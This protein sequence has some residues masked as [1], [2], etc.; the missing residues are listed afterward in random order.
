MKACPNCN[1]Q[2]EGIN[3]NCPKC[4]FQL[5]S[6]EEAK[7][8]LDSMK[9]YSN[10]LNSSLDFSPQGI[11]ATYTYMEH[12]AIELKWV[13]S[14]ISG[15]TQKHKELIQNPRLI[16]DNEWKT[17]V[18]TFLMAFFAMMNGMENKEFS[19]HIVTNP[20]PGCHGIEFELTK[21]GIAVEDLGKNYSNF[22]DGKDA[23]GLEKAQKCIS[24]IVARINN[25]ASEMEKVK[26]KITSNG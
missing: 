16:R 6:L 11:K 21:L 15:F 13:M 20:P 26:G 3:I 24:E 17:S 5:M 19:Q 23:D 2:I 4:G 1:Q 14:A 22:L 18:K 25:T 8:L 10:N 12:V 7:S 9:K